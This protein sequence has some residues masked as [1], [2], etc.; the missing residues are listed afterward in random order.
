MFQILSSILSCN[1]RL[2]REPKVP[3]CSPH[4]RPLGAEP[5][6]ERLPVSS[7]AAGVLLGFGLL[8]QNETPSV[9]EYRTAEN[10]SRP[11]DT[12]VSFDALDDFTLNS[13]DATAVDRIHAE[14]DSM[15]SSTSSESDPFELTPL[16]LE[17]LLDD[18]ASDPVRELGDE[19]LLFQISTLDF[20]QPQFNFM[21]PHLSQ[22]ENG[23]ASKSLD[24][25]LNV[26]DDRTEYGY[27]PVEIEPGDDTMQSASC[28]GGGC[29]TGCGGGC[30]CGCGSYITPWV[31]EVKLNGSLRSVSYTAC[32]PPWVY[33]PY[34]TPVDRKAVVM[35]SSNDTASVS[36]Y[37]SAGG[38]P[39]TKS[40][41]VLNGGAYWT[42]QPGT[43]GWTTYTWTLPEGVSNAEA[44]RDFTFRYTAGSDTVDL[45]VHVG[46]A[47]VW[48]YADQPVPGTT[49]THS[50]DGDVGHASWGIVVDPDVIPY[51]A[52]TQVEFSLLNQYGSNIWGFWPK[53]AVGPFQLSA[54]GQLNNDSSYYDEFDVEKAWT[55]SVAGLWG[56][57]HYTSDLNVNTPGYH[58]LNNNCV[59]LAVG[60]INAAGVP[61]SLSD[62]LP[63]LF[64]E[65]LV[66][67][68]GTRI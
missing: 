40:I 48:G 62:P 11:D 57:V 15:A 33:T 2:T 22:F 44:Q 9:A 18:A 66:A 12:T 1:L 59:S 38:T 20:A 36:T 29:G 25:A 13:L 39:G 31:S 56:V 42:S 26:P 54:E 24:D 10:S 6:E 7:S 14:D 30:G 34:V 17:S 27:T 51:I 4:T 35:Q 19:L 68:G 53:T 45:Y 23:G 43:G 65:A 64:G 21:T 32:S 63:G 67:A 5:L 41:T 58:L 49:N 8:Q 52:T 3:A 60:A 47:E 55:I 16:T 28:C 50:P 37:F 61:F 46:Y